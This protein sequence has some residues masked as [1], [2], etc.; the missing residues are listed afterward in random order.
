MIDILLKIIR[1]NRNIAF[2]YYTGFSFI[3]VIQ[4]KT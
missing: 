3:L 4:F 2:T 1:T